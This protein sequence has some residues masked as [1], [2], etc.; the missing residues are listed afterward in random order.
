MEQKRASGTSQG[1][2]DARRAAR[3]RGPGWG[4]QGTEVAV[5]GKPIPAH[6]DQQW[7]GD[8]H[9]GVTGS[10]SPP[11]SSTQSTSTPL[12]PPCSPQL[13]PVLGLPCS[14]LL[15]L[16]EAQDGAAP[17]P[18]CPV[19]SSPATAEGTTRGWHRHPS[20]R[21][22][23]GPCPG[24]GRP[25]APRTALAP[26]QCSGL[27][28]HLPAPLSSPLPVSCL[29]FLLPPSAAHADEAHAVPTL[30]ARRLLIRL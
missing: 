17:A 6:K 14:S 24:T 10:I 16:P 23:H 11:S 7:D 21:L 12:L 20:C 1:A 8:Q 2:C 28:F 3:P 13:F 5:L 25:G 15:L 29:H 27:G 26:A 22:H 9:P 30:A 19:P 18:L 4:G